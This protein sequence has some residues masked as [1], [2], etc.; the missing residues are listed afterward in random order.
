MNS[1]KLTL[2]VLCAGAGL[3]LAQCGSSSST[4][5]SS[6]T[7]IVTIPQPMPTASPSPAP[8]AS[9][10]P[11]PG[12]SS[13]LPAGMVCNPTPPPLYRMHAKIHSKDNLGRLVLDS[14]PLVMNVDHYCDRVGFGDWKFCDTRPEGDPQRVACD[15]LVTG[16]AQDTGRWGPTWYYGDQLC[17]SASG[18]CANHSTEQFMAIAKASGRYVACASE[19]WPVTT[20]GMRCAEIEI[21]VN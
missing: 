21:V 12:G 14:K 6:P 10:S 8:T 2:V 18:S 5:T 7:P 15:Y 1:R 3:V 11:A 19:N 13:G 20:N 9:P 4:P 17:S 16:K